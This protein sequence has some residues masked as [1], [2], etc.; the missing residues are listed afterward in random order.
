[1]VLAAVTEMGVAG[2]LVFS[3]SFLRFPFSL[4]IYTYIY[5]HMY[6]YLQREAGSVKIYNL[7]HKS[8]DQW[9]ITPKIDANDCIS[10]EV[11]ELLRQKYWWNF[12]SPFFE[13]SMRITF[14]KEDLQHIG[15]KLVGSVWK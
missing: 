13:E 11:H 9:E 10:P 2:A 4:S 1:M 3:F 7:I 12:A 6:I 5:T 15:W 14:Y 8:L